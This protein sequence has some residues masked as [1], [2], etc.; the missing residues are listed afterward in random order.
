MYISSYIIIIPNTYVRTQ[1]VFLH[2]N[3]KL[4][5]THHKWVWLHVDLQTT[6]HNVKHFKLLV[7]IL[8]LELTYQIEISTIAISL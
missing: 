4:K 8:R 6:T 1:V 3:L 5:L 7:P 2:D